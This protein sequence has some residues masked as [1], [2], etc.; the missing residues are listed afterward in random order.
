MVSA[1][2]QVN[3]EEAKRTIYGIMVKYAGEYHLPYVCYDM[4]MYVALYKYAGTCEERKYALNCIHSI[5]VD[6]SFQCVD[7]II[8]NFK[9]FTL[10]KD[11]LDEE[12]IQE[13]DAICMDV[14]LFFEK[15]L[16]EVK[17][18]AN[19]GQSDFVPCITVKEA[20]NYFKQ[21][22][23]IILDTKISNLESYILVS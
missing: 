9:E 17:F 20:E 13:F 12:D 14:L 2:N 8:Q 6:N 22:V 18:E 7:E 16:A 4:D 1:Y 11:Y 3:S 5:I 15:I 10:I 19:F 21:V 23:D